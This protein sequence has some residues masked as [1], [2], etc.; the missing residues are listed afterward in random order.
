MSEFAWT[1]AGL[2]ELVKDLPE[3]ARPECCDFYAVGWA[4]DGFGG[5]DTEPWVSVEAAVLAHTASVL[6]WLAD[7]Q[8]A[9]MVYHDFSPPRLWVVCTHKDFSGPTLLHALVAAAREVGE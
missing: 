1:A 2:Y 8:D 6:G 9:P 7:Q 4:M 5:D 3:G